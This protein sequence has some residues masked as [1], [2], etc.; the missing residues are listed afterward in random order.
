MPWTPATL[1]ARTPPARWR[2]SPQLPLGAS[3]GSSST[4]TA[5]GQFLSSWSN[6]LRPWASRPSS[7]PRT[8]PTQ[9]KDVMMSVMVSGFLPTWS[10]RTWREPLR[11]VKW[12]HS[13]IHCAG[14]RHMR[15]NPWVTAA[16][17][18]TYLLPSCFCSI[19][20]WPSASLASGFNIPVQLPWRHWFPSLL[21]LSSRHRCFKELVNVIAS[22]FN[23][24]PLG[25]EKTS[26]LCIITA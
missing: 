10:W 12:S 15:Q 1:P 3:D 22:K 24:S 11:F 5:T 20:A 4:S 25:Q 13:F 23:A 6:G 17:S 26:S 21:L 14:V 19:L 7:S 16:V 18:R 8:C 9:A 2:K